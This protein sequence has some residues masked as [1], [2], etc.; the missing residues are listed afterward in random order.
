MSASALTDQS[1]KGFEL[2]FQVSS[3]LSTLLS[4]VSGDISFLSYGRLDGRNVPEP[5]SEGGGSKAGAQTQLLK[6]LAQ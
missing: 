2:H 6:F 3:S 1:Q 5:G 4:G